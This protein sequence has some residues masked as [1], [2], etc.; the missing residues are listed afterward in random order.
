MSLLPPRQQRG[1]TLIELLAAIVVL[2][3][4]FVVVL[5]A[6]GY[7][8]QVLARDGQT[9]RMALMA[10]SLMAEH[11]ESLSSGAFLEGTLDGIQWRL[12]STPLRS[13][14]VLALAQLELTL[15]KGKRHEHFV[16]LK[17]IKRPSGVMQ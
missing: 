1:F 2:S 11:G 6:M 14:E 16:T 12:T 5:N 7:A 3:I 13:D 8:P 10:T 17:A 15:V 9:T 4:G